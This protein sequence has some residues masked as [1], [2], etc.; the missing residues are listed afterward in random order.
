MRPTAKRSSKTPTTHLDILHGR[1][2]QSHIN[3]GAA[4]LHVEE[5][6]SGMVSVCATVQAVNPPSH[7]NTNAALLLPPQQGTTTAQCSCERGWF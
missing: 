1:Q 2:L 6:R 4:K 5:R 7:T 3:V